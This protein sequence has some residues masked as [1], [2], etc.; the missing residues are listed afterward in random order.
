LD[1]RIAEHQLPAP[2]NW[3]LVSMEQLL[4]LKPDLV[5][6]WTSQSETIQQLENF[7]I[8]VYGVM[9]KS[10]TDVIKEIQD[11]GKLLGREKRADWLID[12]TQQEIN[13]L[14]SYKEKGHSSAYF[15][16]SQGINHTSGRESTVNDAF[17]IAGVTNCCPLPD[18]HVSI[19]LE[20]L[21]LWNPDLVVMW[22]NPKMGV[23][24]W[25]KHQQI[26]SMLAVVNQQIFELPHPFLCDLWTLKLV[27]TAHLINQWAYPTAN[28]SPQD[29]FRDFFF[30]AL[31]HTHIHWKDEQ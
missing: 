10:Y 14:D 9:L 28:P 19:N 17:S 29:D 20:H 7:N 8:P 5:I 11:L 30:N 25:Q 4:V 24:D 21:L 13:K 2:G 23:A 3:D 31:Y 18:E 6:I 12:F 26:Q 22:P 15:A 1:G 27:Y 16:W